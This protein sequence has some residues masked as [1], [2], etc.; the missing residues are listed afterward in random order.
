MSPSSLHRGLAGPSSYN[1][2]FPSLL[3]VLLPASKSLVPC[4]DGSMSAV[5][6]VCCEPTTESRKLGARVGM[7][8]DSTQIVTVCLPSHL[9]TN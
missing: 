2:L 8:T 4:P 6:T 1:T 3:S 7:W 5:I 9:D